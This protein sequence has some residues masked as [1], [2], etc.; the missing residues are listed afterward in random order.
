MRTKAA[1]LVVL[2]VLATLC[3]H[4]TACHAGCENR[5]SDK[6]EAPGGRHTTVL[7]QRHCGRTSAINTS[8]SIIVSGDKLPDETGNVF[9]SS[10]RGVWVEWIDMSTFEIR[11]DPNAGDLVMARD[12]IDG[13]D[14]RFVPQE[15]DYPWY[16]N[17]PIH[18]AAGSSDLERIVGLMES[19][20]H[21]NALD[22]CG[23][24]ALD[25]LP[26]GNIMPGIS[27]RA[28]EV[29][30]ILAQRGGLSGFEVRPTLSGAAAAGELDSVKALLRGGDDPNEDLCFSYTPLASAA[31][32]G[33]E[34][35]VAVLL[36]NG[37]RPRSG[38]KTALL[39]SD[40]PAVVK[41]LLQAGAEVDARN[42]NGDTPLHYAASL[43]RMEV[44]PLLLKAGADVNALDRNGHTAL[45]NCKPQACEIL[46]EHG[47]KHGGEVGGR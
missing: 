23:E 38:G 6:I 43:G 1:C 28:M 7:F 33:H 11:Y 14:V 32:W 39:L 34:D 46:L 27:R 15:E 22:Q 16:P 18:L 5:V 24:T 12:V 35:V 13:V 26:V 44:M 37:A 4:G 29:R 21:I 41:L 40:D 36:R 17:P 47:G 31:M 19:G 45:D 25:T 9:S 30:E 10:A 2:S 3:I 20:F 42:L 8:V